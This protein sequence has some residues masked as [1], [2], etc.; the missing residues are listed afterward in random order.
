[1]TH[2][3]K[4]GVDKLCAALSKAQKSMPDDI[5]PMFNLYIEAL[6]KIFESNPFLKEPVNKPLHS[7]NLFKGSVVYAFVDGRV[8][9]GT[10]VDCQNGVYKLQ[11]HNSVQLVP[12]FYITIDELVDAIRKWLEAID[13]ERQ[14][15]NIPIR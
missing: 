5:K 13:A 10:L 7:F 11:T 12:C 1:M 8:Y 6:T 4:Q 3:K 14:L 15:F 9:A 2:K